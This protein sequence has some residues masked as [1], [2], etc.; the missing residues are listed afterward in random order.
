MD[1]KC[2][3]QN[4]I[5]RSRIGQVEHPARALSKVKAKVIFL[6]SQTLSLFGRKFVNIYIHKSITAQ[7]GQEKLELWYFL[8]AVSRMTQ[9]KNFTKFD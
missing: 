4:G 9:F 5:Y 7:R 6:R 8:K 1:Q 3:I 2:A